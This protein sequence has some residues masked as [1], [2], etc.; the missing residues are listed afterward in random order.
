M[1]NK[2]IK[3][4]KPCLENWSNMKSNETG[5]Y[6]NL[7]SKNVIDF[8]QLNQYEIS[9]KMENGNVAICARVTQKQLNSPL[10]ILDLQKE[11]NI[12]YSN[13]AASFIIATTIAVNQPIQAKN[14][15][16]QTEIIQTEYKISSVIK[17]DDNLKSNL[18]KPNDLSIV[19]GVVNSEETLSPI[20][21]AKIIFIT[22]KKQFITYTS[23]DGTFSL[24]VPTELI[25]EDNVIRVSYDEIKVEKNAGNNFGYETTD[26]ILTKNDINSKYKVIAKPEMIYLGAIGSYSK[27][28]RIPIVIKNG[29]EIKYKNFIKAQQSM[30]SS[31][32]LE[33]KEFYY[34]KS[35]IAVA[36][37]GNKA[38]YGLYILNDK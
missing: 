24:E 4:D 7:C 20:K 30:K 10:L 23:E 32:S 11:Y 25:D 35:K 18:P 19:K 14:H 22:I 26:Y 2:F 3:I 16:I 5:N 6:C 33:N 27:S 38:K 12:P 29:K 34:F 31:C 1:K 8:T 15:Q 13:I 36:I 28:E 17:N 21:N 9:K 37:Y